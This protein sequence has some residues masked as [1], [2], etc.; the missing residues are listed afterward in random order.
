MLTFLFSLLLLLAKAQVTEKITVKAG[1]DIST[2]LSSHG[3][4]RFPSFMN[5]TV[6]FRDKSNAAGRMNFN[7]FLNEIQFIKPG[8]DTL[9]IANPETIDSVVID[10]SSFYYDKGYLQVLLN[11]N[12]VRLAMRQRIEFRPVKVGAF[13]N[14]S[15]GTSIENYGR[16]ST[17]PYINNN[18]L[19]LN[20]DIVVIK[21]TSYFLIYKKY[22]SIP[23]RRAGFLE[24]F[25][26][27]RKKIEDFILAN[28]TDFKKVNDLKQLLLFCLQQTQ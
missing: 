21:E 11:Y 4:Y 19:T 7:I 16:V 26:D 28:K 25:P 6:V 1:E 20:E 24:I 8:G 3:L 14:Q 17:T 15:P 10:T 12:A 18:Q 2:V 5:G 27:Q 22:I 13:G 9:S 23:A